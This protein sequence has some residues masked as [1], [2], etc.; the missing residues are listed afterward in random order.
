MKILDI[1]KFLFHFS[2]KSIQLAFVTQNR[3]SAECVPSHSAN[4]Q[5]KKYVS[6]GNT[7]NFHWNSGFNYQNCGYIISWQ[8]TALQRAASGRSVP[9][10]MAAWRSCALYSE[11]CFNNATIVLQLSPLRRVAFRGLS[12]LCS[13]SCV[14]NTWTWGSRGGEYEVGRLLEC[15]TE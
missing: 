7:E 2:R 5:N 10:N 13:T 6:S 12:S 9:C 14:Q 4:Y 8:V 1:C 15:S 3:P 11:T